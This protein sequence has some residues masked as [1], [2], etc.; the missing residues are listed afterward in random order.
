MVDDGDIPLPKIP[1]TDGPA[2]FI[3]TPDVEQVVPNLATVLS[4]PEEIDTGSFL[5][6]P[7]IPPATVLG[8]A[9]G[10]EDTLDGIEDIL[11]ERARATERNKISKYDVFYSPQS[12]IPPAAWEYRCE[13]CRFYQESPRRIDK[14]AKCEIVGHKE[15]WMG[16]ER[17][18]PSG[19]CAAWLPQGDRGWLEW[20]TDRLEGKDGTF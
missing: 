17:V 5:F 13:T 10:G 15:D 1:D 7:G 6:S 14:G 2:A 3:S 9:L 20:A 16:G 18:H 11:R 8:Y 19:W 12:P 4:G